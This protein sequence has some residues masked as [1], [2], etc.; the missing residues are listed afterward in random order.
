MPPSISR[1]NLELGFGFFFHPFQDGNGISS[2]SWC[3]FFICWTF[4]SILPHFPV[5]CIYSQNYIN[6][7]RL[8][9]MIESIRGFKITRCALSPYLV[10]ASFHMPKIYLTSYID[11]LLQD[12]FGAD[13]LYPLRLQES[14]QI[15]LSFY[16]QLLNQE[17]Y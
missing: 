1:P 9:M 6:S 10:S 4:N 13:I 7:S 11:Y 2:S 14:S 12:I 3:S 17:Y 15:T 16:F 5:L 8:L